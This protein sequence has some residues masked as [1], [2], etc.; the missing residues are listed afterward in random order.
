MNPKKFSPKKK[1]IKKKSIFQ[2][3]ILKKKKTLTDGV[4]HIFNV[5]GRLPLHHGTGGEVFLV[6]TAALRHGTPGKDGLAKAGAVDP[7]SERLNS[8]T[9]KLWGKE[10]LFSI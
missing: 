9:L 6:F 7:V 3:K 5:L 8:A 2:K 10:K 4:D 1:S